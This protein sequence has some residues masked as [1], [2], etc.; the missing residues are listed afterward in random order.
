MGIIQSG[1]YLKQKDN[2]LQDY[3]NYLP[4]YGNYYKRNGT[5]WQK[6][7]DYM[8]EYGDYLEA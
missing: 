4:E 5:R 8:P 1:D 6:Y 3:N 2:K 7:H